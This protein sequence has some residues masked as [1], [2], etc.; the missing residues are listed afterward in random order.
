MPWITG[1]AMV[2]G[3]LLQNDAAGNAADAQAGAAGN[4]T[5]LQRLMYEEGKAR[6]DPFYRGGVDA[7]QTLTRNLPNLTTA[8][9][10]S[11]VQQDPGYQFGLAEGQKA[12]ER[13]LAARGMGVSGAA[14]K[15]AGRYGNDYATTK[16]GEYFNRDQATK[17]QTYNQLMG[18]TTLGQAAGNQTSVAGQQFGAQAGANMTGAADAQAAGGMAQAGQ[19]AGLLNQGASLY[20]RNRAQPG[21]T[22]WAGGTGF[23]TGTQYGEQDI[24]QYLADGGPVVRRDFEPKVGTRGPVRGGGGG[25]MSREAV[26]AELDRARGTPALPAPAASAPAAPMIDPT[27]PRAVNARREAAAGLKKGGPVRGP[28]GPKDDVI[29]VMASNGEHMIDAETVTA[30]GEGDNGKGQAILNELRARVK[31]HAKTKGGKRG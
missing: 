6:N 9:D 14:L 21:G 28:G 11:K 25:G 24:G 19:L 18:L 20:G 27:N 12:L 4:A 16:T 17:Q 22:N 31:A 29:P 3:G 1:G 5:A 7:L 23:G 8:Y 30:I 10:P 13:S 2:I 15:A 26:L